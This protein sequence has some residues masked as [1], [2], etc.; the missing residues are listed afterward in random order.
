MH[1]KNTHIYLK[2]IIALCF[3]SQITNAQTTTTLHVDIDNFNAGTV[4]EVF[5]NVHFIP[6]ETT[7]ESMIGNI[8]QLEVIKDHFVIADNLSNSIF[9]FNR[10]GKFEYKVKAHKPDRFIDNFICD[11]QNNKLVVQTEANVINV[12]DLEGNF[13]KRV[14]LPFSFYGFFLLNKDTITYNANRPN[15]PSQTDTTLYALHY[16]TNYDHF[17]KV[18]FPYNPKIE[19]CEYNQLTNP[20]SQVRGSDVAIFSL[21]YHYQI[22]A[23]HDTGISHI[24]NFLF[25]LKY[26]IPPNFNTAEFTGK[27][28]DYIYR[29]NNNINKIIGLEKVY[30]LGNYLLFTIRIRRAEARKYAYNLNTHDLISFDHVVGDS[31]SYFLPILKF[32]EGMGTV[33]EG[34]IYSTIPSFVLDNTKKHHPLD[35]YSTELDAYYKHHDKWSNSF[36]IEADLKENL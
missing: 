10:K 32:T 21:P 22:Y 14:K 24:Y 3:Y 16:A 23:L 15:K 18:S 34:H 1:K 5:K 36:I 26:S 4:S 20:F 7:K 11:E 30:K 25:P 2:A 27:K 13:I 29:N 9:F 19:I 31:S 6:L 33:Y 12:F 28:E 8:Y 17:F 35:H